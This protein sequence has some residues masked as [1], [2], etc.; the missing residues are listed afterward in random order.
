MTVL[1]NVDGA[2]EK[3]FLKTLAIYRYDEK[4]PKRSRLQQA[5]KAGNLRIFWKKS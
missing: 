5:S 1:D 3:T 2:I 4:L